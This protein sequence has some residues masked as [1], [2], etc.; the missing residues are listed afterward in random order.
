MKTEKVSW[1]N[2]SKYYPLKEAFILE[3][4]EYLDKDL[5]KKNKALEMTES[6]ELLFKLK[7]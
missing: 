1:K 6:V 2:I 4:Y 7:E 5:L 3:Y